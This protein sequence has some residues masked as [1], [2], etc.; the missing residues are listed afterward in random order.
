MS[1]RHK[2]RNRPGGG[3]FGNA[4]V[5]AGRANGSRRL[6]QVQACLFQAVRQ[7]DLIAVMFENDDEP[8]YLPVERL[9]ETLA[10][11]GLVMVMGN[12]AVTQ[13]VLAQKAGEVSRVLH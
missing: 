10:K 11:P 8:H 5:R 13:Y 1:R 12:D 9:D 3:G 4:Q 7:G 6:Q 2:R